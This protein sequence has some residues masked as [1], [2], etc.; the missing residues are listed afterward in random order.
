MPLGSVAYEAEV[1]AN[2][3]RLIWLEV[4]WVDKLDAGRL[5]AIPPAID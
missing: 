4:R 5:R 3:E 1:T 2:G